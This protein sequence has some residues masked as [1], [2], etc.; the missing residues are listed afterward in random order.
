MQILLVGQPELKAKL[1][2]PELRQLKQ[3]IGLRCTIH[4]LSFD[5]TGEYIRHR[6]EIARGGPWRAASDAEALFTDRAIARIAEY[7]RG[8]PRLI[9]LVCDH[10]LVM[11]YADQLRRIDRRTVDEAIDYLEEGEQPADAPAPPR[12][13]GRV[14]ANRWLLPTA[15]ATVVGCAALLVLAPSGAVGVVDRLAG[16]LQDLAFYARDLLGRLLVGSRSAFS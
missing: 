16:S 10:S 9:N 13:N 15:V 3:R 1:D 14:E 2:K 7:S 11:G 8:I 5:Q 12:A 4:A 6:L